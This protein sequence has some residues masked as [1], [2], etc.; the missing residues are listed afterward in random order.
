MTSIK[1]AHAFAQLILASQHY[2]RPIHWFAVV[3]V[4]TLHNYENDNLVL[5]T[6]NIIATLEHPYF[7]VDISTYTATQVQ[8]AGGAVKQTPRIAHAF[9]SVVNARRCDIAPVRTRCVGE[10]E[11]KY[12]GCRFFDFKFIKMNL[13][14][15]FRHK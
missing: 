13:L 2:A 12:Y 1:Y 11:D 5:C 10:H 6:V 3:V 14:S 8:N 9:L 15:I 7:S 4:G